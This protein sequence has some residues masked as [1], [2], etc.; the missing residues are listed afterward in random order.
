MHKRPILLYNLFPRLAGPFSQW[1]PH[2]ERAARM[3]F[4]HLYINPIQEC[5]YSGSAYSIKDYFT[6]D[7]RYLNPRSKKDQ[8]AQFKDVL[9]QAHGLGLKVVMDLVINHT[10]FDSVLV[11]RYPEWFKRD[12][13]GEFKRASAPDGT[14]WGDLVE[15]D[16][17]HSLDR[18]NL[19]QYWEQ[20]VEYYLRLGVDGFRCDAAYQVP[21]ALWKRIMRRARSVNDQVQFFAE[22]LGCEF[23]RVI[24]LGKAGFDYIFNSVK[25]WDYDQPWALEQHEWNRREGAPSISFPE[26]HDT[27][28]LMEEYQG[29][30]QRVK[31]RYLFSV[32]FSTGLMMPMGFEFGFRKPLDVVNTSPEDWEEPTHDLVPFITRANQL[33]YQFPIFREE[34]AIQRLP[35][36]NPSVTVLQKI[37][38]ETPETALLLINRD[39]H[40]PQELSLDSQILA[41]VKPILLI[42]CEAIQQPLTQWPPTFTLQPADLLVV[43]GQII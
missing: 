29:N 38:E 15:V 26:S 11:S 20:L 36:P 18:E 2:M 1:L 42:N 10:A 7:R 25:W 33:K 27:P 9:K 14:V 28:R 23:A 6:I 16:N 34:T 39:G 5:G 21:L 32:V 37:R 41:S 3:G 13:H 31:Q 4:T 8:F 17:E 22:S 43:S 30:V 19:W 12:G 35:S 24:D 40:H